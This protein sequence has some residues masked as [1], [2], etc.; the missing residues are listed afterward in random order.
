MR[1]SLHNSKTKQ[2]KTKKPNTHTQKLT[3]TFKSSTTLPQNYEFARVPEPYI[4]IFFLGQSN[5]ISM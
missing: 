2:E 3:Y 5:F 1:R 4:C